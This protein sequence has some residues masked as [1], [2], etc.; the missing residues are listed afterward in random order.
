MVVREK[1]CV[2]TGIANGVTRPWQI[3]SGHRVRHHCNPVLAS[4]Y[5]VRF[6]TSSKDSD[7]QVDRPVRIPIDVHD[8]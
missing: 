6:E 5:G 4:T 7:I 2:Y 1:V 3:Y 8:F